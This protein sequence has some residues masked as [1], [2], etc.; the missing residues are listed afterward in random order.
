MLSCWCV[1]SPRASAVELTSNQRMKAQVLEGFPKISDE[2]VR[3]RR[4]ALLWVYFTEY[5]AVTGT[6]TLT[7]SLA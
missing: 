5:L 7:G 6:C 3:I 1:A 2:A 4:R